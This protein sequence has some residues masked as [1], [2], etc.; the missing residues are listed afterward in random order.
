MGRMACVKPIS[1]LVLLVVIC[2]AENEIMS[3]SAEQEVGRCWGRE[4]FVAFLVETTLGGYDQLQPF[5]RF[6]TV[7]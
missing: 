1:A 3:D 5:Q 4:G 2:H 6:K 7:I